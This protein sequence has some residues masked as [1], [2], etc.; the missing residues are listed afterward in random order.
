VR[1]EIKR[2]KAKKGVHHGWSS[3]L[4]S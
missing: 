4:H 1:E 2:A 3:A